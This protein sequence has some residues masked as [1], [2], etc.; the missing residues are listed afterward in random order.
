MGEALQRLLDEA[1][2]KK[3]HIRY[4]RAHPFPSGEGRDGSSS[5][6]V[7]ITRQSSAKG[8]TSLV[9]I[10]IVKVV[11]LPGSLVHSIVAP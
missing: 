8:S 6:H 11:P 5:T 2:I 10:S 3:V 1:A 7:G 4:C 9:I